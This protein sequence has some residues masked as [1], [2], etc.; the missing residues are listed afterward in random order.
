[1]A[2]QPMQSGLYYM[3]LLERFGETTGFGLLNDVMDLICERT[4]LT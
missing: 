4:D 2:E 3:Q 1:M